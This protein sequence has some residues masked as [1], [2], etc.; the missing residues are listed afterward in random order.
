MTIMYSLLQGRPMERSVSFPDRQRAVLDQVTRWHDAQRQSGVAPL[1]RLWTLIQVLN[2]EARALYLSRQEAGWRP[3]GVDHGPYQLRTAEEGPF[4]W[5]LER[6]GLG[7]VY[8]ALA[9]HLLSWL[10]MACI[11]LVFRALTG[12]AVISLTVPWVLILS[13]FP[14]GCPDSFLTYT[15]LASGVPLFIGL[16][17]ADPRRAEMRTRV[18][19]VVEDGALLGSLALYSLVALF[20]PISGRLN[21]VL[22]VV[23]LI[24]TGLLGRSR[25]VLVRGLAAGC[26]LWAAQLPFDHYMREAYGPL[27]RL[28]HGKSEAF[29]PVNLFSGSFERPGPF[30][31]PNGDFGYQVAGTF[32]LYLWLNAPEFLDLHAYRSWGESMFAK[33]LTHYPLNYLETLWKRLYVVL[34]HHRSLSFGMYSS[35]AGVPAFVAGGLLVLLLLLLALLRPGSSWNWLRPL[36]VLVPLAGR[37]FGFPMLLTVVHTH[38]LYL[39]PAA[40][41]LF[42]FLPALVWFAAKEVLSLKRGLHLRRHRGAWVWI[43]PT[44]IGVLLGPYLYREIRKENHAFRTWFQIHAGTRDVDAVPTP[45]SLREEVEAIRRIGH[46]YPGS[47]DMFG[48]WALHAF[49]ERASMY[50]AVLSARGLAPDRVASVPK[51]QEMALAYYRRAL[52]EAPDNPLF[53]GYAIYFE[54]GWA[55]LTKECLE[56]W[57]DHPYAAYLAWNVALRQREPQQRAKYSQLAEEAMHE[58]LRRTSKYRPGFATVPAFEAPPRQPLRVAARGLLVR[59]SPHEE[60]RLARSP[61]HGSSRF[62]VGYSLETLSGEVSEELAVDGRILPVLVV[63]SPGL[64]RYRAYSVNDEAP[65]RR[66]AQVRLRAGDRGASLLIRD[67]YVLLFNPKLARVEHDPGDEWSLWHHLWTIFWVRWPSPWGSSGLWPS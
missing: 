18:R 67:Q 25:R 47:I 37:L 45:E 14:L 56:R 44:L 33:W 24:W 54:P 62:H 55:R 7:P 63:P 11:C 15:A 46:E 51:A 57:P 34:F 50:D 4:A 42:L 31:L 13:G 22:V 61:L 49:I 17:L 5:W 66:W 35:P 38:I 1:Q 52:E 60:V 43:V 64:P 41:L 6:F 8:A 65:S 53:V 40:L 3:L 19:S 30:G 48:A 27:T 58:N 39:H 12:S 10:G 23:A 36:P 16:L 26:L 20:E 28:N 21:S 2:T 9:I 59:L 32:D 29:V